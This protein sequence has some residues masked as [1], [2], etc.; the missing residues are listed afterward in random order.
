MKHYQIGINCH[1]YIHIGF[2]NA[3]LDF[4]LQLFVINLLALDKYIILI[5]RQLIL[6]HITHIGLMVYLWQL[7]PIW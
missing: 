3:Y 7:I 2:A 1:K 5:S 4:L 6:A